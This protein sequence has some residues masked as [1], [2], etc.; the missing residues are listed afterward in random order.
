MRVLFVLVVLAPVP[1]ADDKK[2]PDYYPLTKGNKWEYR[3]SIN[4]KETDFTVELGDVVIKEGKQHAKGTIRFGSGE[5]T[6][7]NS[8][9]EKGLYMNAMAGEKCDPPR[10]VLKYPLK[11]GDTWTQKFK[12]G[13]KDAEGKTTVREPETIEVPA[14]KFKAFP[15]D[16]VIKT[17]DDTATATTWY[18]EGVGI[19]K[20]IVKSTPE[21][22][23]IT[24]ELKKFTPGK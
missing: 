13:D 5:W 4:G 6:E 20:M 22:L 17:G 2:K 16:T 18:A 21:P 11:A 23:A 24:L 7:E 19:V 10:T 3:I 15:V 9:D 12:E 1:A 8:S 14:G